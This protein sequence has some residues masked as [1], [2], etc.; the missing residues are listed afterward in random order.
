MSFSVVR[1]SSPIFTIANMDRDSQVLAQSL[2]SS[3][4]RTYA[5]LV[6]QNNAPLSTP[7]H[8]A[9]GQRSREERAQSQQYL[10]PEEE[11][12]VIRFVLLMSSLGKPVR[13]M[14][15]LVLAFSVA[16]RRSAANRPSKPPGRNW[17]RAFEKRTSELKARKV[18]VIDWKFH[19]NGI[20]GKITHWSE[21]IGEVLQDP[22]WRVKVSRRLPSRDSFH[23]AA[24]LT[25]RTIYNCHTPHFDRSF[26]Q[27]GHSAGQHVQHG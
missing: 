27:S 3:V 16:R 18:K 12:A 24:S 26:R 19:E 2:I 17:P 1:S 6:E 25:H 13:I 10:T 22:C 7:H 21:V 23:I 20:Y 4:P 8:R 15:I 9:R 5:A 14:S 11:K